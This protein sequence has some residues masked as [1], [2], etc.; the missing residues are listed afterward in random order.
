MLAR[1][2]KSKRSLTK[3]KWLNNALI[4]GPYIT[5]CLSYDEYVKVVKKSD[6]ITPKWNSPGRCEII[7]R[8]E[9]MICVVTLQHFL[10]RPLHECVGLL[11]HEASHALDSYFED[12]GERHPSDEFR[13]YAYQG[14]TQ[15]LFVE[16]TRRVVLSKDL[17][18]RKIK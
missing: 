16:F 14:I 2:S 18:V 4:I 5:L 13:A 6:Y 17:I 9:D 7:K 3:P 15:N 8:K 11:N 12:I 1:D 10:N